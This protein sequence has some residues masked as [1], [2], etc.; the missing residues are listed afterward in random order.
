MGI[1]PI[2]VNYSKH[3]RF[4]GSIPKVELMGLLSNSFMDDLLLLNYP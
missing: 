2:A 1:E 4:S 3:W